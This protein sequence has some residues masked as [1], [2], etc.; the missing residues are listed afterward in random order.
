MDKNDEITKGAI[1]YLFILLFQRIIGI[2]LFFVAAGTFNYIRGIVNISLYLV[3]SIIAC[4]LMFSGHKE[5]LNERGKKQDNTKNWDKILSPI[6]FLLAYYVIYIIAGLGNRF[7][8]KTLP[9]EYFFIGIILYLIS[10]VFIIWPILENKHFEATSRIQDNREQTVIKTGPYKIIRHPG[11]TGIVIWAIASSLIFGTIAVGIV[12][13]II[14]V[15]IC[16]RTYM[17][18]KMLKTELTGYLEYSKFVKYRL[19][20]FVW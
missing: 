20:P 19:I 7:H 10:C 3:V 17:E 5:T 15:V 2:G 4:I 18:D 6:Y 11:Y 16:I 1:R 8:W 12:G 13:L 14:I 9:M